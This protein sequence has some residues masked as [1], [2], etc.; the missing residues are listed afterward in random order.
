MEINEA[1]GMIVGK[2]NCATI[3]SLGNSSFSQFRR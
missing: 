2:L 3:I 1:S